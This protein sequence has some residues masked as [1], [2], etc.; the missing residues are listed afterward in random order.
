MKMKKIQKKSEFKHEEKYQNLL[1]KYK[2]LEYQYNYY[3]D[4]EIKNRKS[5]L[6]ESNKDICSEEETMA[7][8]RLNDNKAKGE[9]LKSIIRDI[10]IQINEIEKINKIINADRKIEKFF[11]KSGAEKIKKRI[12]TKFLNKSLNKKKKNYSYFTS[13]LLNKFI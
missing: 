10:Q 4:M 6:D 2:K 3:F 7:I 12:N 8:L 5:K 1:S 13:Q 9:Y 11:G